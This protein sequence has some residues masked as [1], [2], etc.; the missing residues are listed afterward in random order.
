[1]QTLAEKIQVHFR[2]LGR[3]N[4]GALI[5]EDYRSLYDGAATFLDAP[6]PQA[7]PPFDRAEG[8][9]EVVVGRLPS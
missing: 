6:Y 8:L 9:D 3:P 7:R 2:A 4:V 1:M 5:L